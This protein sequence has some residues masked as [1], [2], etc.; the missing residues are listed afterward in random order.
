MSVLATMA[1]LW[2]AAGDG[3]SGLD[4]TVFAQYGVVG[5]IAILGIWFAKGAHQ[6]ERERADRLE[7]ENRRL[8][9]V[10]LERVIPAMTAATS[11]AQESAQLLAALQRER[12]LER[13]ATEHQRRKERDGDV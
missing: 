13:L 3:G 6:R 12:E 8:N 5:A 1:A 11:A 2:A 4:L 7:T 10:I 9:D